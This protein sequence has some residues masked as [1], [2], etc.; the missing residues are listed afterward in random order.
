MVILSDVAPNLVRAHKGSALGAAAW[1]GWR[2][3]QSAARFAQRLDVVELGADRIVPVVN[4]H[5][6]GNPIVEQ[7]HAEFIVRFLDAGIGRKKGKP[8]APTWSLQQR[9][10]MD[11][12]G[13][14]GD[15]DPDRRRN[16]YRVFIGST[17]EHLARYKVLA[18]PSLVDQQDRV[19]AWKQYPRFELHGLRLRFRKL[20]NATLAETV[21]SCLTT[22]VL[23]DLA[24]AGLSL[25]KAIAQPVLGFPSHKAGDNVDIR[26]LAVPH[27]Q[28][29]TL[30]DR[31][32]VAGLAPFVS[33]RA[34]RID[35][36]GVAPRRP[37]GHRIE[38]TVR[39]DLGA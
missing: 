13:I 10:D 4:Q 28:P 5:V 21:Q 37:Q 18:F 34:M 3:P 19:C 14:S 38:R 9:A 12:R 17:I 29:I 30:L 35:N 39:G 7:S 33:H 36:T 15:L 2:T 16:L 24:V 32:A 20:G 23:V 27:F 25:I 6:L 8:H 22:N 31:P 11:H 1:S 26:R